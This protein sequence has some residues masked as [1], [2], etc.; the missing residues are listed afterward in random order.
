MR[1]WVEQLSKA[2]WAPL[3]E[4]AH[5]VAFAEIKPLALERIDFA[6]VIRNEEGLMGYATC[7][8]HD[9]ET[10]YWAYGGA[11]P[12]TKSSSLTFSGYQAVVEFSKKKYKRVATLIENTN[13]VMLKFAMKVGFRIVGIRCV[14]GHI[15]LEH[16][17]EFG[18]V[19]R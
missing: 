18:D 8:E 13:T 2:Q 12:G 7:R 19:L 14:F 4:N 15:Y 1:I 6:L 11:F 17:L 3:S 16:I 5:K 9:A 10:L